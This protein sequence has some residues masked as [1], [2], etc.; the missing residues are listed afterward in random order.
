MK[1]LFETHLLGELLLLLQLL[2]LATQIGVHGLVG[3]NLT[4]LAR[5][6]VLRLTLR[7]LCVDEFRVCVVLG[8]TSRLRTN[9]GLAAN[10]LLELAET[11][12]RSLRHE[13]GHTILRQKLAEVAQIDLQH[14]AEFP[15]L[16]LL[17][18]LAIDIEVADAATDS[19]LHCDYTALSLQ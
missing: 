11:L 3:L 16:V 9:K 6:I 12:L 10:R 8:I 2:L 1:T 5:N 17:L 19:D 13:V 18:G 4:L 15:E 14:P 7:L